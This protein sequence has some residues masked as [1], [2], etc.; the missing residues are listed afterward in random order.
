MPVVSVVIPTYNRANKLQRAVDSVLNQ[1]MGDLE[2]IVIDDASKDH[3]PTVMERY[4]DSR[5]EYYR[6][7]INKNGSA[8]RNTGIKHA[9]GD[10]IAFLDS[11]DEWLPHKLE[12]QLARIQEVTNTVAVYCDVELKRESGLKKSWSILKKS[13]DSRRGRDKLK[14]GGEDLIKDILQKELSVFAGSTLL[15]DS[16]VVRSI[17]GF[18]ERFPR[19]QDLEFLIRVLRQGRLQC[20]PRPLVK[21]HETDSGI[22]PETVRE[23]KQLYFGKF[24][25][26][27]EELEQSGCDIR[28]RHQFELAKSYFSQGDFSKG[29][30]QMQHAQPASTIQYI[31]MLWS[32]Y[33]GVRSKIQEELS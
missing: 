17:S 9:T 1:T 4:C 32:I 21:I 16:E 20:V 31:P 2:V 11:D 25:K 19:H 3:T 7:N 27:I 5:V 14:E 33:L 28:S 30:E 15:V 26:T 10:Y 23:A 12:L 22:Q 29:L 18:D 24:S 6:H 13:W 8:A